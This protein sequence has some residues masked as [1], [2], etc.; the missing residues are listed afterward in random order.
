MKIS[1]STISVLLPAAFFAAVLSG[2]CASGAGKIAELT[3]ARSKFDPLP[4]ALEFAPPDAQ[5]LNV[6]GARFGCGRDNGKT[7]HNGTDLKAPVGTDVIALFDGTVSFVRSTFK[8]DE[9]HKDSLGNTIIV[10]VKGQQL[11][12]RYAHLK[13]VEKPLV[14]EGDSIVAGQV[15]GKTG[16]TGNA[17]DVPFAHLHF[18]ASTTGFGGIAPSHF[19]D[20]EPY[21][22]TVFPANPN[23]VTDCP[24]CVPK[25]H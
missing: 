17:V 6:N 1:I 9:Y 25:W 16:R 8:D 14:K 7:R 15:L 12:F 4:I 5:G 24:G 10:K 3:G 23:C 2:C 18:E 21:L 11:W 19:I 13:H 20:A 22:R